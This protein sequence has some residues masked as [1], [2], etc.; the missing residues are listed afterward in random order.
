M[1]PYRGNAKKAFGVGEAGTCLAARSRCGFSLV[2]L[3]V[4]M[5]ILSL[6]FSV[7]VPA[8]S[9]ANET[10]RTAVCLTNLRAV[11]TAIHMYAEEWDGFAVPALYDDLTGTQQAPAGTKDPWVADLIHGEAWS[12]LFARAKYLPVPLSDDRNEIQEGPSAL[13]CPS[14]LEMVRGLES[15]SWTRAEDPTDKA[16]MSAF[17]HVSTSAGP[18]KY[19]HNWYGMSASTGD[20]PLFPFTKVPDGRSSPSQYKLSRLGP[21]SDIAGVYDGWNVHRGWAWY[22]ISARHGHQTRTN[23][24]TLDGRARTFQR[25]ELPM[26]P[27]H[28]EYGTGGSLTT[29]QINKQ[30]PSVAWR[31]DQWK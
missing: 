4:I 21:L 29:H 24:M 1:T 5:A 19:V 20:S 6:L 13:R 30:A 11:G 23:V 14:G 22:T 17:P 7:L 9:Q 26:A 15:S 12:T 28:C 18:P 16:W 3:L 31:R 27:F 25:C 10:A 8:L 2:E